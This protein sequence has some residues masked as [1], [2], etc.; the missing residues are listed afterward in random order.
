[1]PG[2]VRFV[3]RPRARRVSLRLDASRREAIAVLPRARDRRRAEALIA[4][5]ADWLARQWASLPPPMPFVPD[6]LIWLRGRKVRLVRQ[7]GRGPARE[8]GDKLSVPCPEAAP[9]AGRV[10]R[11]L[12]AL[13]R[14]ALKERAQHHA[15]SL[16]ADIAGLTVRDTRSR[17]GSCSAAG[18][19]NFSWR[20][21]CAPT[22][23]LD[24]VCAH[25]VAHLVEHNHGPGFWA[26]VDQCVDDAKAPRRWL[27]DHSAQLFAVGAEH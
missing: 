12:L 23:V 7:S 16:K 15:A 24:Y 3:I 6:G 20:L 13:A 26:L 11:A 10:R 4:Q 8:E 1:M 14:Q 22:P 21:I 9:F 18:R 17:W 25:E 27:R 19:L 2:P 5:R